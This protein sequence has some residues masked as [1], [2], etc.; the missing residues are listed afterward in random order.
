MKKFL[1][2]ESEKRRIL[3][4]HNTHLKRHESFLIKEGFSASPGEGYGGDV[5]A[6]KRDL[7]YNVAVKTGQIKSS[8]EWRK[9][10]Q[11]WGSDGSMA[12]N[13]KMRNEMCD[14]W[15]SGD[16][17]PEEESSEIELSSKDVDVVTMKK[18]EIMDLLNN[19][20]TDPMY[21]YAEEEDKQIISDSKNKIN[22]ITSDNVC[23]QENLDYY[24]NA[25]TELNEKKEKDTIKNYAPNISKNMGEIVNKLEE[26][27]TFCLSQKTSGE[28]KPNVE[29][30]DDYGVEPNLENTPTEESNALLEEL[31]LTKKEDI[32]KLIEA[33]QNDGMYSMA[34]S[35]EKSLVEDAKNKIESVNS[36]NVC[37]QENLV[38]YDASIQKLNDAKNKPKIKTF[39]PEIGKNMG[40]LV[41]KLTEIKTYCSSQVNESRSLKKVS[42]ITES[43]IKKIIRRIIIDNY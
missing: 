33:I 14:G 24:N 41:E 3:K 26:I 8:A 15:R 1:I 35:S 27:K 4:M 5:Q 40:K 2:S 29:N 17:F 28:E 12:Q 39:A 31:I 13:L 30:E 22:T 21:S 6:C 10:R 18:T 25:I 19:I 7:P 37:S 32:K 38:Y 23:N 9:L 34:D 20:E 43:E 36:S 16:K 11:E 42:R